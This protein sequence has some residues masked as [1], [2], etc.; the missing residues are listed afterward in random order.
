MITTQTWWESI[1]SGPLAHGI[2]H[3]KLHLLENEDFLYLQ[4]IEE[5]DIYTTEPTAH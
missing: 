3:E 1:F 2:N 4:N 5:K